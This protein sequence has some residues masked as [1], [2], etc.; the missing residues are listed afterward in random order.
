MQ[1]K[2]K[3]FI[4][5]KTK[6]YIKGDK[7]N[8][9]LFRTL[10]RRYEATI[11]DCMYKIQSLSENNIIIPEHVDITGEADKLLQIM[12]EAEDKVAIMRKYYVQNKAEK[13]LL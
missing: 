13:N 12:A 3:I 2:G 10:L 8:D 1:T 6:G 7:M 11:E 9:M 4:G 5:Y